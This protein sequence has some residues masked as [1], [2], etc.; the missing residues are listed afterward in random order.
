MLKNKFI[1]ITV[2]VFLLLMAL[3][4]ATP[5]VYIHE[6]LHH[7]HAAL[8]IGNQT[9]VQ[10]QSADDCDFNEYN[11]PVYFNLFKFISSFIP[12]KPQNTVHRIEKAIS[13]SS[14]SYAISLLRGP[15]VGD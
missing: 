8:T 14:I 6:L 10:S 12:L 3:W 9:Q 7:N 2:S 13:L 5:K 15:P 4:I 1:K 11:K